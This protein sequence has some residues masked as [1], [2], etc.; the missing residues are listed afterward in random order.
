MEMNQTGQRRAG[1]PQKNTN[2][3][4]D[5]SHCG[6]LSDAIFRP[7]AVYSRAEER[8]RNPYLENYEDSNCQHCGQVGALGCVSVKKQRGAIREKYGIEGSGGKDCCVAFY[9]CACALAQHDAEI[10]SRNPKKRQ[11]VDTAGYR[12]NTTSMY[13]PDVNRG[14][15]YATNDIRASGYR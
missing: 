13:M 12:P 4:V 15:W 1:Q 5:L 2:W 9:C 10:E 3:N 6:S 11:A 8:M 14:S 7:C